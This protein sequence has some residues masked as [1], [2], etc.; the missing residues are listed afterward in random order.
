MKKII[1]I[2]ALAFISDSH[3]AKLCE[4]NAY[5]YAYNSNNYTW[6]MG[7]GCAGDST[8]TGTCSNVAY[9]GIAICLTD[10]YPD[11]GTD[12]T[13][14]NLNSTSTEKIQAIVD[15]MPAGGSGNLCFCKRTYPTT[16]RWIFYGSLA[17]TGSACSS[18]CAIGCAFWGRVRLPLRAALLWN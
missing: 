3:A 4:Y 9:S 10:N 11:S 16:G 6:S 2:I 17:S 18:G 8:A 5:E 1:Y 14:Y 12:R 15:K 7:I 13:L